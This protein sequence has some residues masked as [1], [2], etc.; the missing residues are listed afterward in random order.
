MPQAPGPSTVIAATPRA[1][2][3]IAA[4]AC[5]CCGVENSN[6]QKM[7]LWVLLKRLAYPPPA[8]V[9]HIALIRTFL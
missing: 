7:G 6:D 3:V 1:G 9:I 2:K 8:G 5:C 4:K